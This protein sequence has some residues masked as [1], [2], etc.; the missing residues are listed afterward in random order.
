MIM[1]SEYFEA[2]AADVM[3]TAGGDPA[4]AGQLAAWAEDAR[5]RR[6][7]QRLG[8]IVA[9]D[10]TLVAETIRL[11]VLVGVSVVYVT[12]ALVELPDPD[13]AEG[14]L[15]DLA[16]GAIRQQIGQPIIHVPAWQVCTGAARGVVSAGV[17]RR[18]KTSA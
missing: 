18:Q 7:W 2:Q 5:L 6:D 3:A 16:C 13:D 1:A 12:D 15:L 9:Y 4:N 10:G 11:N 17:P 8:V 14:T